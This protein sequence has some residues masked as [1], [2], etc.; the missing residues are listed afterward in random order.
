MLKNYFSI[1]F[2]LAVSVS[3]AQSKYKTK[4]VIK[5]KVCYTI[6]TDK[7][8]TKY[9]DS[10]YLVKEAKVSFDQL[11]DPEKKKIL[12]K[13]KNLKSITFKEEIDVGG[14]KVSIEKT[15]NIDEYLKAQKFSTTEKYN[16]DATVG[17]VKFEDDK[18]Y[19]NPYIN[20]IK[21]KFDRDVYY[22][23]L[24]NRQTVKLDF[25]EWVINALTI[26]L[27]YRFDPGTNAT[28]EF[29]VDFNAN[30]FIGHTNGSTKFLHREKVD[31]KEFKTYF[32]NGIYLGVS[33]TTLNSVNTSRATTPLV[34]EE[35]TAGLFSIGYGF[36][37][38]IDKVT[39]MTF[40]G[41]D[42]AVGAKS[43]LWNYE[44]KPYLGL[45]V[46]YDLFKFN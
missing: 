36:G 15:L 34:D 28:G 5:D 27:K 37:G 25:T 43:D 12:E 46:G 39:L 18:L 3:F 29:S 32:T 42:F 19:L 23:K 26:P 20:P 8:I 1:L 2:I 24:K 11:S 13:I 31:N 4:Y 30:L 9:I 14:N 16:Q 21:S 7:G 45:G 22:Y 41:I 33:T 38:G 17:Y 35:V 44:G 10:I 6:E 40:I